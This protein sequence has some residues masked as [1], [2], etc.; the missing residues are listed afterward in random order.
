[1]HEHS[2]SQDSSDYRLIIK[3]CTR[4]QICSV[5]CKTLLVGAKNFYT[6]SFF[7]KYNKITKVILVIIINK[8]G[9]Y[10]RIQSSTP[11]KDRLGLFHIFGSTDI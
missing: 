8:G 11:V 1:M 4:G 2:Y 6:Y 7:K 9:V 10:Q 3:L 5:E